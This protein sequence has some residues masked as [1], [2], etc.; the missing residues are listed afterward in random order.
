MYKKP[1]DT[2]KTT[3]TGGLIGIGEFLLV[4]FDSSFSCS[5]FSVQMVSLA[6]DGLTG[7]IQD[8]IRDAHRVQAFHM[9]FSMNTW[10][11][12]WASIGVLATGEIFGLYNFLTIYPEVMTRMV[13][14]GIAG[15][16]GQVS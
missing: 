13:L 1:T 10:S 11:C 15:A 12:L 7:S 6:F 8:K 5:N 2:K 9:M 14:L 16:C 4:S 3:E